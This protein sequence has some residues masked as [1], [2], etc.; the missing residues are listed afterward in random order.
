MRYSLRTMLFTLLV[1][2]AWTTWWS[3]GVRKQREA[4]AWVERNGGNVVYECDIHTA[5]TSGI[6]VKWLASWSAWIGKDC[7]SNIAGIELHHT[8]ITDDELEKLK[9]FKKLRFLNIS[10][11][12][13][14]DAGVEHLTS[15][16]SLEELFIFRTNITDIGAIHLKEALPNTVVIVHNGF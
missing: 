2:G 16:K 3:N 14:T 7:V 10:D 6:G 5:E 15:W 9:T 11:S 1:V 8:Q 13:I 4:V 12:R